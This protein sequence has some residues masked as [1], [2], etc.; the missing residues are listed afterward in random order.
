MHV[1]SLDVHPS[2]SEIHVG[3]CNMHPDSESLSPDKTDAVRLSSW[4][5]LLPRPTMACVRSARSSLG[6]LGNSLTS[7]P[8]VPGARFLNNRAIISASVFRA[9]REYGNRGRA[10]SRNSFFSLTPKQ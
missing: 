9:C 3:S 1:P 8:V 2:C 5:L 10:K 7:C 6:L 4:L